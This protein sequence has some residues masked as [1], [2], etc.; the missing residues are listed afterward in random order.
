[1][2]L[3]KVGIG[4]NAEKRSFLYEG[5]KKVGRIPTSQK[6]GFTHTLHY[7]INANST[8]AGK[9]LEHPLELR[10]VD[11]LIIR[12]VGDQIHEEKQLGIR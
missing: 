8:F 11:H 3:T 12:Q 1:L 5:M 7:F 6:T 2:F 4:N 9:N 10:E